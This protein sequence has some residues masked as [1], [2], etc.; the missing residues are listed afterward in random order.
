MAISLPVTFDRRKPG[1]WISAGTHCV[2]LG[3][4]LLGVSAPALPEAQEGV[5]VEVITEQQLS[6]IMKGERQADK[7]MPNAQSR[8][9]R[10]A[11]KRE[12]R[13]PENAKVDA[14]RRPS[15]PRT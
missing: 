7:P 13:E 10:Q 5:P 2:L 4:V 6:E 11:D 8:A 3:A 9:D 1:V 14:P 15:A 12:E